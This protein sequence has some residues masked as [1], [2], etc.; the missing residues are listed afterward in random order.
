ML[1]TGS[2]MLAIA[3]RLFMKSHPND[4][5]LAYINIERLNFNKKGEHYRFFKILSRLSSSIAGQGLRL[6]GKTGNAPTQSYRS[7]SKLAI[8]K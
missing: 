5:S 8:K 1:V 3:C 7:L 6:M 4:K 2:L